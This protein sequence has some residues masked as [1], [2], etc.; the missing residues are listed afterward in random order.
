MDESIYDFAFVFEF[1]SGGWNK[2]INAEEQNIDY[3]NV[4]FMNDDDS[5]TI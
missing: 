2:N 3:L 4:I 1:S 5:Y